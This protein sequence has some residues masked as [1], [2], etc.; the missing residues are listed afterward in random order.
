[1]T[2]KNKNIKSTNEEIKKEIEEI[3]RRVF[4]TKFLPELKR[5]GKKKGLLNVDKYKKG[6]EDVLIERLVKGKQLEDY[7]KNVLLEMTQNEGLIANTSTPKNVLIQKLRN[8]KLTDLKNKRLRELAD[9]GGVQLQSQMSNKKIIERLENP[10]KYYNIQ[11]LKR[12]A[13][14]N[15]L[16]VKENITLP[17]L[18]K[19]LSERNIITTTPIAAKE[20][21]LGVMFLSAPIE[22]VRVAK[23]KAPNA[24]EALINFKKYMKTLKTDYITSSRLKKLNE[25]LEKK[26]EE[27]KEEHDRIFTPRMELSAFAN[28]LNQYVIDGDDYYDARSFFK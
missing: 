1:M 11:N 18:I 2:N 16:S 26:E 25:Q 21:N 15:N 19:F 13:R 23:K 24:R 28:Y 20:S 3:N 6:E 5:I 14:N 12:L 27:A 10:T 7:P 9:K 8:P 17:E 4:K 22:V